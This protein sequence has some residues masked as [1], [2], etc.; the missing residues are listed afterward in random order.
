MDAIM[1]AQGIDIAVKLLSAS[2]QLAQQAIAV[3]DQI[4][5]HNAAGTTWTA[6]ELAGWKAKAMA[7]RAVLNLALG[8]DTPPVAASTPGAPTV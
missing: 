3:S 6:D 2:T 7:A 1:L 8:D 5:A 4:N